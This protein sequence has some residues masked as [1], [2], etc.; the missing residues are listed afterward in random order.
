MINK[1]MF[2][3]GASIC[4]ASMFELK[5]CLKKYNL[6]ILNEQVCQSITC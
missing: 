2:T 5:K 6:V 3:I 1:I 4:I